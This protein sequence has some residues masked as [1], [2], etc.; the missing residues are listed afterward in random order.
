MN[1]SIRPTTDSAANLDLQAIAPTSEARPVE[2]LHTLNSIAAECEASKRSAQNWLKKA[3]EKYGELGELREGARY[4][5]DAEREQVL[6]FASGRKKAA[7]V[8]ATP[9]TAAS[10]VTSPAIAPDVLPPAS[11]DIYQGNHQ[12]TLAAPDLSGS[13]DLGQLRSP[14]SQ[15]NSYADPLALAQMVV[16][17]NAQIVGAMSADLEQRQQQLD[18]T[19][20]ALSLVEQSNQNLIAQA[21]SYQIEAAVQGAMLNQQTQALQ[22]K[23]QQQ[24]SL[25]KP[26]TGSQQPQS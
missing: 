24:Q 15:V 4:F 17:Q 25:G 18:A 8:P 14:R 19:N 13:R 5:S 21:Q 10:T 11:I 12:N 22:Q 9:A 20:Q 26:P 7:P 6:E 2:R 23:V 16:N 1:M 3:V